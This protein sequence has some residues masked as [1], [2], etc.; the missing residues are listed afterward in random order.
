MQLNESHVMTDDDA[1][2]KAAFEMLFERLVSD[3]NVVPQFIGRFHGSQALPRRD[4]PP[5]Y[6][7]FDTLSQHP[8]LSFNTPRLEEACVNEIRIRTGA[9]LASTDDVIQGAIRLLQDVTLPTFQK[10]LAPS[11]F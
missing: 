7:S 4:Y 2:T 3:D 6:W 9:T 5:I 1:L 11:V 8:R 10:A